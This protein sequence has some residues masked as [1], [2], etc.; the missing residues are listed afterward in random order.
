M[1]SLFTVIFCSFK[2]ILPVVNNLTKYL[3]MFLSQFVQFWNIKL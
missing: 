3:N 2:E 1:H